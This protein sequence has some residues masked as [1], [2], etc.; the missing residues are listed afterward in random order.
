MIPKSEENGGGRDE[1]PGDENEGDA[2][3]DEFSSGG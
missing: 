3:A 1:G 2:D